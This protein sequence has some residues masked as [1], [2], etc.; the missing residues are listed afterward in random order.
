MALVSCP[1]SDGNLTPQLCHLKRDSDDLYWLVVGGLEYFLFFHILGI[2][3]P[4][5]FH[6][7]QMGRSTTN[8]YVLT[9]PVCQD[10]RIATHV[11][12]LHPHSEVRSKPVQ[13]V[14]M[15]FGSELSL[16]KL[17]VAPYVKVW[18]NCM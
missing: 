3:I 17:Y 4:V 5:D 6:I 14:Q 10:D 12:T 13:H 11:P 15:I 2:I 7:F 18:T 8:Q 9:G 1:L 16:D